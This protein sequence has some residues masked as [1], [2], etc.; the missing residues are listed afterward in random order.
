MNAPDPNPDRRPF[1]RAEHGGATV[2]ALGLCSALGVL[3]VGADGRD[4]TIDLAAALGP[5]VEVTTLPG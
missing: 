4:A 2:W 5:A 3:M 1:L